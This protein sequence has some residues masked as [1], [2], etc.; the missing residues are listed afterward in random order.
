MAVKNK[1]SLISIISKTPNTI[2]VSKTDTPENIMVDICKSAQ[3][4]FKHICIINANKPYSVLVEKFKK[5]KVDYSKFYFIDCVS[6]SFMD[7]TS[8]KQSTYISSPSALTELAIALN[9]LP[10]ETDLVILDSFSSLAFYNGYPMTLRFLNS[11]T[12]KFRKNY[13]HAVYLVVGE[14]KKEIIGDLSLFADD[15]IEI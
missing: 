11:I 12:A 1:K 13:L 10:S 4:K 9:N 14:T 7:K 6:A 5:A 15:I 3:K 8:S 2:V